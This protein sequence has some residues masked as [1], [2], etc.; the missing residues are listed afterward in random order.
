ME[1][2]RIK[3]EREYYEVDVFKDDPINIFSPWY[4]ADNIRRA[5]YKAGDKILVIP[6]PNHK[7]LGYFVVDIQDKLWGTERAKILLKISD[8]CTDIDPNQIKRINRE[9]LADQFIAYWN[10]RGVEFYE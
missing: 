7:T 5:L 10:A 2:E 3:L 4:I 9:F 8:D 6:I 1:I